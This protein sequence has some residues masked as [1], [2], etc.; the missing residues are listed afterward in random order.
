MSLLVRGLSGFL[1]KKWDFPVANSMFR[2]DLIG[3][4]PTREQSNFLQLTKN[5]SLVQLAI[6][7]LLYNLN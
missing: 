1:W 2:K 7:A 5:I 3:K 4:K 6:F